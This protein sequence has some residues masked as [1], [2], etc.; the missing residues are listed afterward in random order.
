MNTTT[1]DKH[2]II[3]AQGRQIGVILSMEEYM[4]VEP[5]LQQHQQLKPSN[6]EKADHE[7]LH[8]IEQAANDPLFLADLREAMNDFEHVD[9]EWWER[10]A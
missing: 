2:F 1:L 7:K 10:S 9:A 3:D 8:K 5:I 4:L 6:I